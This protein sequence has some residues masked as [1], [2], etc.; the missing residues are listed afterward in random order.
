[1]A[2]AL[3]ALLKTVDLL[4]RPRYYAWLFISPLHCISLTT[5]SLSVGKD[6]NV[7]TI[8][9]TLNQSFGVLED[10]FLGGKCSKAAVEVKFLVS[11]FS[12]LIDLELQC[13]LISNF[14]D[15]RGL[16]SLFLVAKG[17]HS[18][19][20]SDLA[21]H[22]LYDVVKLLSLDDLQLELRLQLFMLHV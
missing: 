17:S 16:Y 20:D 11:L 7:E 8:Q 18:A 15:A 22:V 12:L 19:E 1:M 4:D 10:L 5:T 14:Y 6:A 2:I 13:V 9:S 3:H 21:F